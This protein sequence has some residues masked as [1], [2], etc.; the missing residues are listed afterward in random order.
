[1]SEPGILKPGM[2][3]QSLLILAMVGAVAVGGCGSAETETLSPIAAVPHSSVNPSNPIEIPER[4]DPSIPPVSIPFLSPPTPE[5]TPSSRPSLAP[6]PSIPPSPPRTP[7]Q[8]SPLPGSVNSGSLAQQ[9]ID[10]VNRERIQQ[11]LTALTLNPKLERAAQIHVQDRVSRGF[12]SHTGSD[13]SSVQVRVERQ[14]YAWIALAENIARGQSS[15]DQVMASWMA[16]PGHRSTI[17]N[18]SYR[19]IGVAYAQEGHHWVQVF[20]TAR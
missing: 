18:P 19:E 11:G 14:N 3:T 16:S 20:G 9:V 8:A 7:G 2:S 12:F 13:G 17:L 10:R 4:L 6:R 1:M 15:P 5:P